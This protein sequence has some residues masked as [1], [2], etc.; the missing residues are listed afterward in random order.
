MVV[1]THLKKDYG[2]LKALP[3]FNILQPLNTTQSGIIHKAT[4]AGAW[5]PVGLAQ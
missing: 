5:S 4:Q 3:K 2:N 1:Q